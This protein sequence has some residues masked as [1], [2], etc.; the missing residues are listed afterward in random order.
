MVHINMKKLLVIAKSFGGGGSEVAL[1]EFLNHL[2]LKKYDVSV[3][4]MDK[5]EEYKN[6]LDRQI[7][8]QYIKFD[9]DLYHDL[10][11]MY[12]LAG[13]IIKK[14]NLNHYFCIYDLIAK[15]SK[16]PELGSYDIAIDFYGYGAF[17]TAF[18][19][20]NVNAKKKA[21]WLH[22]VKM[23]WIKNVDRYFKDIDK[24]YGVSKTIKREFDRRYPQFSYMSGTFFNV[25][26]IKSIISNST[27][28]YPKEFEDNS[29]HIVTVGRLT[30]QKGYDIAIKAANLLKNRIQRFKWIIIGGGKEHK[31]LTK[32]IIKYK[33]QN[34]VFLLGRKE[35]P[36]PYIKKCD[37]YIQPSR[38]EGY[39]LSVLEARVLRKPIIVS[40]LPVFTEQIKDQENG[41]VC[42]LSPEKLANEIYKL[43][44][45]KELLNKIINNVSKEN[46]SFDSEMKKLDQL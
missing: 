7:K 30:E 22:D 19:A 43:Y 46:I 24:V 28:F 34:N 42:E 36:Y 1:I 32:L 2:D 12:S 33:L 23:P 40:N 11:S 39:G 20:L 25:V 35:N 4:L 18:L 37:I 10:A 16:M 3:L 21:I 17:T 38:H 41:L 6:R 15:H 13:K 5:D 27:K 31:K 45:D 44:K 8:I 9:N 26:D 14:I 29:F